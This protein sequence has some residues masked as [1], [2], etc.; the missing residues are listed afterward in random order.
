[1]KPSEPKTILDVSGLKTYFYSSRG[2]ARAVDGVSFHLRSGEVLGVVGE[3]GSGKSVTALSIMQLIPDPPGK[4]VDGRV[5]FDGTN[6]LDLSRQQ[7]RR[8]R[9]NRIAMIFQEPMTSLNPVFTIGNQISEMFILHRNAGR[10]EALEASIEMLHRV[11]IPAPRRRIHEYP[12]QLS[13]GM[14]QRAMIAMALACDPEILIAD[15]PTT[16]LDVTVQAQILEL[17]LKLKEDFGTAVQMITHD[18][19]VIAEMAQR[20]VVMY[21]GRVVEEAPT[22][23][24]FKQPLHPYTVGLLQSIPI[25]GSRTA[26]ETRRLQEIKGMVPNLVALP[27]GCKFGDRCPKVME[28]CRK[29]EPELTDIASGRRVRCW[30]HVEPPP[31]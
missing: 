31:S 19:G 16:A 24:I 7:M 4:I 18:L 25:L 23:E 12:H 22:L 20:I 21:A 13:G 29:R 5:H 30:L 3:S 10:K 28:I 1:M 17:M 27:E 2:A 6:L 11:Q 15:E 9:G 26:G 8:I 14:R